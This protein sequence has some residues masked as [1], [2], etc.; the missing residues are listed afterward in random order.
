M[1]SKL[2]IVSMVSLASGAS[3]GRH[4]HHEVHA[5]VASASGVDDATASA[6]AIIEEAEKDAEQDSSS[7]GQH[8]SSED[9]AASTDSSS[10]GQ[11]SSSED[12]AAATDNENTDADE[13]GEDGDGDEHDEDTQ[14]SNADVPK[15]PTERN[16]TFENILPAKHALQLERN[17]T[18]EKILAAKRALQANL[19]EQHRLTGLLHSYQDEATFNSYVND[20]AKHVATEAKS[21][22]FADMLGMM[23]KEMRKYSTPTYLEKLHEIRAK[24]EAEEIILKENLD[25]AQGTFYARLPTLRGTD[26]GVQKSAAMLAFTTQLW[27]GLLATAVSFAFMVV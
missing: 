10:V 12:S 3:T 7:V 9:S 6:E 18:F 14:T 5:K 23:R 24:R 26:E 25:K 11:H 13:D 17:G 15:A 19:V 27:G 21:E 2:F 20:E 22:A 16:E 4:H 8:S 1:L